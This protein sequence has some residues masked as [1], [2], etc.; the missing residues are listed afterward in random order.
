MLNKKRSIEAVVKKSSKVKVS[1]PHW[2]EAFTEVALEQR[3]DEWYA[4][5][6][7]MSTG[8]HVCL[9]ANGKRSDGYAQIKLSCPRPGGG[10]W[11]WNPRPWQV[12]TFVRGI[13][14]SG[15]FEAS[16]L[17]GQGKQGCVDYSHI[18]YELHTNNLHRDKCHEMTGCPGCSLFHPVRVC[19]HVPRCIHG[20]TQ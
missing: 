14:P 6:T 19:T 15:G 2:S 4:T 16:H 5:N 13:E 10:R 20:K 12:E 3:L 7:H 18:V 17:C 11:E 9:T 8:N 1:K